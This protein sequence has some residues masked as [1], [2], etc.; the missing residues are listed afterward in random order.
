MIE[1]LN[2][3]HREL[4]IE[5]QVMI[6]ALDHGLNDGALPEVLVQDFLDTNADGARPSFANV[7][8]GYLR[9]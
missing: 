9:T 2:L 4:V 8:S 1:K 6:E 7:A 3:N 5:R